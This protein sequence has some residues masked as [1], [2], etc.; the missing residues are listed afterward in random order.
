MTENRPEDVRAAVAQYVTALHRAYLAQADTFAPAVRG[1][2]PLLAG[3]PPVTVAAVGVRNLHLL[4]TREGLGPLRGQE[5][6]VDG[7]LDG[8]GWT[9][10]FYDPVVVPALGTL[11]ETAGPAYDGVKTALGI[12]TVVYHVVAQPGSGLTPHHAGHV[13]SGLASGHSAA[14]RDFETIRSRV[15]GR[16]HLVDELAGAAHAGLPRAQA[17][18]AKEIAPHN[19]GV[20]AAAES[21]DPDS[22]RKALLASVGGRSDWRPPS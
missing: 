17:L 18:L 21:L 20:A 10:R 8:L 13:G 19:A 9:L 5:V 14:A 3:G 1:A 11:D 2:M 16:E 4:A 15:R 12:S 22:I 7:S 6:E